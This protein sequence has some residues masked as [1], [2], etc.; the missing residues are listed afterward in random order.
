MKRKYLTYY[1]NIILNGI[2][3]E[4]EENYSEDISDLDKVQMLY[5]V[6]RQLHVHKYNRHLTDK[7]L[8]NEWLRGLPNELFVTYKNADILKEAVDSGEF[9][10]DT[11]DK[12]ASFVELYWMRLTD[13]FFTLKDNL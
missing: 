4:E 6:Y 1:E 3:L 7:E 2:N 5:E 13:A 9:V 12:K 10:L 8:F 11:D